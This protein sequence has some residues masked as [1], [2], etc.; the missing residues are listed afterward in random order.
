[1]DLNRSVDGMGMDEATRKRIFVP[2]FTTKVE[3]KGERTGFI[4]GQRIRETKRRQHHR[5]QPAL[6]R[7]GVP[8]LPP[9][10]QKRKLNFPEIRLLG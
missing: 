5:Y 1:M 2:F 3:G 9:L 6:G 8:H 4:H 7:G 10:H